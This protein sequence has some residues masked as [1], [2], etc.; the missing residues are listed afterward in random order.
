M[1]LD[2]GLLIRKKGWELSKCE[3]MVWL[4]FKPVVLK[5]NLETSAIVQYQIESNLRV[6]Q[7]KISMILEKLELFFPF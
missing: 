5:L 2:A 1:R 3:S 6:M 4:L 7:T